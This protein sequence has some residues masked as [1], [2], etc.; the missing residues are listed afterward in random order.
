[1]HRHVQFYVAFSPPSDNWP[2]GAW[3]LYET[4]AD[5]IARRTGVSANGEIVRRDGLTGYIGTYGRLDALA[6]I[7]E[8]RTAEPVT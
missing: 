2:N 3:A 5:D 1:M 4:S 7:M 6:V 8:D